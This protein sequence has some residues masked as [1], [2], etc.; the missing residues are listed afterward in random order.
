MI[1]KLTFVFFAKM[2]KTPGASD[3]SRQSFQ[4]SESYEPKDTANRPDLDLGYRSVRLATDNTHTTHVVSLPTRGT[5]VYG[6]TLPRYWY[7]APDP[8]QDGQQ[9]SAEFRA[10]ECLRAAYERKV[11]QAALAGR[12]AVIY[13]PGSC[14]GYGTGRL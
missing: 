4:S 1:F 5:T 13:D 2:K 12:A 6:T 10:R 11:F 9:Q 8:R 3:G 7:P 14:R